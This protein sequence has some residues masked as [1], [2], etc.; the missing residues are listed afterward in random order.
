[1]IE[2]CFTSLKLMLHMC[3]LVLIP[4]A[5]VSLHDDLTGGGAALCGGQRSGSALAE[6]GRGR[7]DPS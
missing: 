2:D 4:D 3:V 1:M 7:D 6:R 5:G